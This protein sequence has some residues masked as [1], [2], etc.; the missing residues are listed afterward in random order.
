M[1]PKSAC[2]GLSPRAFYGEIESRLFR[3]NFNFLTLS[4]KGA[5]GTSGWALLSSR[6]DPAGDVFERQI[7]P[8]ETGLATN[9]YESDIN[10][11]RGA[12]AG[13]GDS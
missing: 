6:V 9:Q 3:R 7:E 1:A 13:H 11:R 8:F 10:R 12:A 5:Q 2:E 4:S